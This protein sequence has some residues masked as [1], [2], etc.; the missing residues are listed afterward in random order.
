[1]ELFPI[2]PL[3]GLIPAFIAGS[4]GHNFLG[5]WIF[6]AMLFIVAL[7][8]AGAKWAGANAIADSYGLPRT[9]GSSSVLAWAGHQD[10]LGPALTP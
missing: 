8:V 6:G 7:P 4:K 10:R 2:L 5:W 3:I 1:M 9:T